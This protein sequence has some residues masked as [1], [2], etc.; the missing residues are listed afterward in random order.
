MDEYYNQIK[1]KLLQSEIYD[2]IKDYS[3]DR[4]KVKSYF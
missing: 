1:E 4:N 3:K 2:V